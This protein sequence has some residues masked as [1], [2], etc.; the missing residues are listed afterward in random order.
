MKTL[1][2][3]CDGNCSVSQ[4]LNSPD[5]KAMI[6]K[7]HDESELRLTSQLSGRNNNGSDTYSIYSPHVEFLLEQ[8][9][10]IGITQ[11]TVYMYYTNRPI[12]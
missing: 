2:E 8:S 1:K 11:V 10:S 3:I 7:M 5:L 12:T 4:L 6:I 9:K